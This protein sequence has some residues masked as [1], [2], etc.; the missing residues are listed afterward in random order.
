MLEVGVDGAPAVGGPTLEQW[1][2]GEQG[3]RPEEQEEDGAL[4]EVARPVAAAVAGEHPQQGLAEAGA[5]EHLRRER[6]E[7]DGVL[8][9]RAAAAAL[10]A[11]AMQEALAG[12]KTLVG[13][14]RRQTQDGVR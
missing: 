1:G 10:A 11:A 14:H 6:E 5:G 13:A 3:Q 4:Q 12:R 2:A 7:E 8:E 9:R